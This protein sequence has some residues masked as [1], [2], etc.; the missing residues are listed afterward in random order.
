MKYFKTLQFQEKYLKHFH[1]V[2]MPRD[3]TTREI[4]LKYLEVSDSEFKPDLIVID[5]M[6]I[7]SP[8]NTTGS[9]WQDLGKI[10]AE[11]HEFARV[12]EV[13]VLSASQVNRTKDGQERYNNDRIARSG[14]IPTNANIIMQIANRPDESIR[15]DMIVYI[16]KMRDGEQG[17]FILS[18]DFG[19]MKVIDVAYDSFIDEDEDDVF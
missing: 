10:S 5:Y 18:K 11:L 13:T 6:G 16:T 7:M 15:T 3:V 14:V 1:I 19:K 9:D 8:N 17:H 2:D 12:Y 4:E